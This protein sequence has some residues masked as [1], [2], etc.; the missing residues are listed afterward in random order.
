MGKVKN[1]T[2]LQWNCRG[3]W[4]NHEELKHLCHDLCPSAICL[5][6]IM[7]AA[8]AKSNIKGYT[9]YHV[10]DT[11]SD[12]RPIG[13]SSILIRNDVSH[14]RIPLQTQ[15]QA[16]AVRASLSKIISLCSIY[17]PPSTSYNLND[18]EQI[19][20]QLP[21][22]YIILGDFN[23]HSDLWGN[24][25][26]DSAGSII[27][28]LLNSKELCLLNNGSPTYLHPGNGAKTAI[29]LTLC[30]P[31]I[32]QDLKWSLTKDQHGSDHYPIIIEICLPFTP[33]NQPR[34]ILSK[35]DW[36]SFESL[37]A[38]TISDEI[39][40]NCEDQIEEFSK[41][42]LQAASKTIPKSSGNSRR[43]RRPWFDGECKR[44][45]RLRNAA[46]QRYERHPCP[47]FR[48]LYSKA[49][50]EA[51]RTIKLKKRLSWQNYISKLTHRT[52][53]KQ[54][55]NMVRKISGRNVSQAVQ[56]LT[57]PDGEHVSD[58]KSIADCLAQCIAYNSST[59][60]YTDTFQIYKQGIESRGLSFH[61]LNLENYNEPFSLLELQ[62]ALQ[63]C[64]H[65][66]VGPDEIHYAFLQHLPIP[67]L[68]I[69][70]D[71]FNYVWL[72]ESFPDCWRQATII[73][74]PKPGKDPSVPN[75]YRPIALTSCLC[76]TMERMVN[77]RL[78]WYLESQNHLSV[79]QSGFRQ[80]RSTL[81]HLVS[82]EAFIRDSFIQGDHVFTVFFDL[83]KAY[84]TTWKHGIL[85][86]LYDMGMRG[87]MPI[88]ISNF[89]SNREFRVR[90]GSTLSD[91]QP[92]EM[93]VPQGS[94]LSVTLFIVKINSI[95]EVLPN[96][97]SLHYSLFVDDFS[98][99]CRG[100]STPLVQR[101]LQLCINKVQ[102]W[103]DLNGFRFS[104]TKT[105]CVHFCNQRKLHDDP[106][107]TLNSSLIPVV[108]E[109]KFLGLIFDKKL[110]FKAHI[111]ATRKK[112]ISSMNLLKVI[113]HLDW[114]ADRKILLQLFR[115]FIRSKI[116]YGSVVYG[117]ARPSYIKQLESIHNAGLRLCTGAYRTSPIPSLQVEANELPMALRHNQ[118][119]LQYAIK[120]KSNESNPAFDTVF[121]PQFRNFYTSKPSYI[122]PLAYRIEDQ[123]DAFCGNPVIHYFIPDLPP[124]RIPQPEIDFTLTQ[125]K[126]DSVSP[127]ELQAAFMNLLA[128]YP[129]ESV[130]FYTD[131]SKSS[132]AVACSFTSPQFKMRMRLP[133]QMSVYTSELIAILSVLKCIESMR[134]EEHFIVC[135]DS[136]SG[137]MAL[138]NRDIKHP[139]VYEILK[140]LTTLCG[141]TKLVVF[142]WCPAH[143]GIS[144]NERADSLAKAALSL[145]HIADFPIP[146]SDLRFSI[147]QLVFN[148]WQQQWDIQT[149]NKLHSIQPSV[150]PWPLC[151]RENRR[152]EIVLAR[153][154]IGHT[155]FTHSYL[156][157]GDIQ[158]ECYACD[159]PLTVH[160]IL[161]DCADFL[162]VRR[163]YFNVSSLKQLF[164]EV[165]PSTILSFLREIELFYQI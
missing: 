21:A 86:D 28:N 25:R 38:L 46:Q 90:V 97:S 112:C 128:L 56:H 67:V 40:E 70:L 57:S 64:H 74:V 143:V 144:G 145:D 61:S 157:R 109:A 47:H 37:C 82:L 26:S 117:A 111:A 52:S 96:C 134:E 156:P 151:Q 136:L 110:N 63:K 15:L 124:W 13:G 18:L 139:C 93:G 42:I 142:I 137:L 100:R 78:V 118:L 104:P 164:E 68:F 62:T 59:D 27:E 17:I 129:D 66:A 75:N 41:L 135:S 160:H 99:S 4:A 80:N 55:W 158:P 152:E 121:A 92:Q 44:V 149:Q 1:Q 48:Q 53:S 115:S 150:G 105:V 123:L 162:H 122:R 107:L 12:D 51:R 76:K 5:Q 65:T 79:H 102:K 108:E 36:D 10:S 29:D 39:L 50:A 141:G 148:Q 8:N 60:H 89:L 147:K 45:V 32:F 22:P 130:I 119:S 30:S 84:D 35:A 6:E 114:G 69:L 98:M 101:Q 31:S 131:G 127:L 95:V 165:N 23:A 153:L 116:D 94:I 54:I 33:P 138:H 73:P 24:Q 163:K 88:F 11:S 154:R 14:Q 72:G 58:Q 120:L 85:V 125:F 133:A 155:Y 2:I 87:R 81:D 7:L 20:N 9:S 132:D 19:I 3:F 159:C 34:W 140:L 77:G 126:K 49:R 161:I 106:T 113:S 83:E 43:I 146:A 16:V 91:P 103:A 71:I